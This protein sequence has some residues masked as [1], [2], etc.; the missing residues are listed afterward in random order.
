[1]TADDFRTLRDRQA[2]IEAEVGRG[3]GLPGARVDRQLVKVYDA[4]KIPTYPNFIFACNPVQLDCPEQAGASCTEV[5]DTATTLYVDFVQN[6]PVAGD[7]AVAR[8]VGGRWVARKGRGRPKC[9]DWLCGPIVTIDAS[10]GGGTNDALAEIQ[11]NSD[12]TLGP[13]T[14]TQPGAG[15][16]ANPNVYISTPPSGGTRATATALVG[17]VTSIAVSDQGKGYT[18][19]PNVTVEPSVG[20]FPAT[21]SYYYQV[22]GV[23]ANG[24]TTGSY[25]AFA[26]VSTKSD[27]ISLSWSTIPTA[28]YYNLYRSTTSGGES[29]SPALLYSGTN[30]YYHDLGAAVSAGAAPTSNTAV[31]LPPHS[32]TASSSSTGGSFPSGSYYYQVTALT[33]NGE[34]T[35]SPEVSATVPSHSTTGS[36]SLSW[37]S[38]TGA[39][40]Y[41]VYRSSFSGGESISP[42]LVAS[43]TKTSYTDTGVALSA[44]A[45]PASNTATLSPPS[46]SLTLLTTEGGTQCTATAVLGTGSNSD[47]VVSITITYSGS[48][49]VLDNP[50]VTIDPPP[51][52]GTQALANASAAVGTVTSLTL[53]NPGSGYTVDNQPIPTS[54][55]VTITGASNS[56]GLSIGPITLVPGGTYQGAPPTQSYCVWQGSTKFDV[57][58]TNV[59]P[60][61]SGVQLTVELVFDSTGAYQLLCTFGCAS[62]LPATI[63]CPAPYGSGEDIG[64]LTT[65]VSSTWPVT[66]SYC[67]S[68]PYSFSVTQAFWPPYGGA[69]AGAGTA[70]YLIFGGD[71]PGDGSSLQP[72]VYVTFTLTEN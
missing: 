22:T 32:L 68:R 71:C 61:L 29:T 62:G 18:S 1:M 20:S 14:L 6:A 50:T 12:G 3:R 2:R 17:G 24:E 38:V 69:L 49:Y 72:N 70:V 4:G 30:T 13:I 15:Y 7:M 48:L 56:N 8:L 31:I 54:W 37:S 9:T 25:Q 47:K 27:I 58:A 57:P 63:S 10:P 46:L 28:L 26:S 41:N 53:T 59:C 44:G 23:T 55:S 33:A 36:V 42:A 43:V 19:V 66:P 11:V 39:T 5:V 60:A 67:Y 65:A 21:G 51:A 64:C 35:G 34:T 16:D 52:G 45:V 40:G